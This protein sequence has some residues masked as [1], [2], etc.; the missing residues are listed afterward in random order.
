MIGFW[1][2]GGSLGSTPNMLAAPGSMPWL[3]IM[4]MGRGRWET[5][6]KCYVG[7]EKE[8]CPFNKQHNTLNGG[9]D[10][11]FAAGIALDYP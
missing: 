4:S 8:S 7:R 6:S 1:P 2:V 9:Q 5:V 10:V 11:V 3:G